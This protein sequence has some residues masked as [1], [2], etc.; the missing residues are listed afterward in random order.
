MSDQNL[1]T[2]NGEEGLTDEQ[3]EYT[4]GFAESTERP[5]ASDTQFASTGNHEVKIVNIKNLHAFSV[6]II[7]IKFSQ[8]LCFS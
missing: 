1:Q 7:V 8:L 3:L 5:A 6:R 4:I 2:R